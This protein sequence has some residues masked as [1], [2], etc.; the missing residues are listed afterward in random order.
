MQVICTSLQTD[1]HA[2]TSSL[3]FFTGWMLFL[4]PNQQHRSNEGIFTIMHYLCNTAHC[5]RLPQTKP[6]GSL[7]QLYSTYNVADE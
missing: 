5:Q 1:N 4:L 3:K 6:D 7:Q 2:S